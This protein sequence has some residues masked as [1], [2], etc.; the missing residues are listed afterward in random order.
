MT[1]IPLDE[2]LIEQLIA[3]RIAAREAKDFA[4]ADTIR[5]QLD[6]MG[7]VIIDGK[8]EVTGE[9]WTTWDRKA[10]PEEGSE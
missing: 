1:N 10:V 4:K 8:D 2:A 3:D 5:K 7:L 6:A 9:F